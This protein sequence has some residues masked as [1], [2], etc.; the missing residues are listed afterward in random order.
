LLCVLLGARTAGLIEI[1]LGTRILLDPGSA[2]GQGQN[3]EG[4]RMEAP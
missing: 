1:K 3:A 4:V 2:Q